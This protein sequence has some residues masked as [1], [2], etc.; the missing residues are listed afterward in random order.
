[1][2][3]ISTSVSTLEN[4]HRRPLGSRGTSAALGVSAAALKLTLDTT[5]L[6]S[7]G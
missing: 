5:G 7:H 1:L 6:L 2:T 4:R 3:S